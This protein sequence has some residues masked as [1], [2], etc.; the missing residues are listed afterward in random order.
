VGPDGNFNNNSTKDF[1][2]RIDY[3]FGGMGLDGD[4][5]GVKLPPENWR[6]TSFRF[7]VLGYRGD[8]SGVDFPITDP[9]GNPFNIQQK[10]FKRIGIYGSLY[11][12]DLNV[13]GGAIH[14][15]DEL[16]LRDSTTGDE[17]SRTTHTFDTWFAEADY[18]I[19]PPFQLA[20]RYENLR[21]SD[22]SVNRLQFLTTDFSFLVRANI[23]LLVEAR[24]DLHDTQNYQIATALRAAF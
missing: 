24:L 17:I 15:T 21:P 7:G 9:D 8:G 10:V 20:V 14:G 12:G 2:G 18:V 6:E 1:Y 5:T 22:P 4:T 23:K 13:F 11:V 3:K 16:S 19:K